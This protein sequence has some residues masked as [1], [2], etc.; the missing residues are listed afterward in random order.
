MTFDEIITYFEENK[1]ENNIE[2][3]K[4]FGIFAKK[5][6]GL[7][8]PLIRSIAKK[9]GKDHSLA[10][11]LWDYGYHD[12][13]ILASL[14]DK[15]EFVSRKQME[16]WASEFD[17][18]AVCDSTCGNLFDKVIG[19]KDIAL[20]WTKRKEEYVK[21]AGFVIITWMSVHDKKCS[22]E[23]FFDFLNVIYREAND[24][25]KYV[26]K[27]VNWSL[28]QIGKR[29]P[30]LQAAAIQM[31]KEI[32]E[33]GSKPAKWIANDALRELRNK[34]TRIRNINL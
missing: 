18:W 26:M 7:S 8:A 31:S 17:N 28:R 3:M 27:A 9:T 21:R 6:Y 19:A 10:L 16:K 23:I 25:R 30:L 13:R 32:Y 4:R 2:G 24:E 11:N 5:V 20:E 33:L 14:I 29:N 34:E 22:D 15:P 12:T 1:N